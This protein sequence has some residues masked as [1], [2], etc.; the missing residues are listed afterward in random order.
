[1]L[2]Q[3]DEEAK[4]ALVQVLDMVL[5]SYGITALKLCHDIN[6]GVVS[7][8]LKTPGKKNEDKECRT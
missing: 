1:M 6:A 3:T 7:D 8:D 5:K 4:V 2:I